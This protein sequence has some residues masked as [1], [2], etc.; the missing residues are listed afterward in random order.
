MLRLVMVN[1]VLSLLLMGCSGGG[2]DDA[3]RKPTHKV[4]GTVTMAGGAVAG[5]SVTFSPIEGQ[6][7]AFAMT[8]SEGKYTL[9]T[10]DAGDGAVEGSYKVMVYKSGGGSSEP[11]SGS[12][13]AY[14]SGSFN[15]GAAH[16][17]KGGGAAKGSGLPEKYSKADTTD[18]IHKV[19]AG[20]DNVID[21]A[22]NP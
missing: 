21:L 1:G 16:S 2:G 20:K 22:L 10:Y 3:N 8:D 14:V 18:L 7:V 11:A 17:G 6:P 4:T 9:T 5:A 13:E 15:P 19:E 12:H